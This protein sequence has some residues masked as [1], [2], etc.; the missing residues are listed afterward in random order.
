MPVARHPPYSPG[1]AVFP[2][3]V[4]R[5]SSLPRCTA[6]PSGN[7][8][9]TWNLRH[10]R[11]RYLD[12]V[13]D[14]GTLLPRG[15][16]LLASPPVEPLKRPGHGPM[17]EA[18]AR[19][20]VPSHAIGVVVASQSRMQTLED[21]PPRQMPVLFEPCREPLASGVEL[22]ACGAP[23]DAR[24]T[25]PIWCPAKRESQPGEAPLR[26]WVQTAEP[27][28][29]GCLWCPLAVALRPPVGP[30]SHKPFRVRLPA[31]GPPPVSRLSAPPCFSPTA[32]VHSLSKPSV[33]GRV[34]R[35]IGE[36]GRDRPAL[37]RPSLGMDALAIRV[38]NTCLQPWA[39]QGEQGPIVDAHAPHV[40]EPRRVP[41][42]EGSNNFIPLSTTHWETTWEKVKSQ[43]PVIHSSGVVLRWSRRARAPTVWA[44]FSSPTA[45]PWCCGFPRPPPVWSRHR[46][47]PNR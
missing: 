44:L 8:A 25:V 12:A 10:T 34:Q 33:Q 22:L 36:A 15:A 1:R 23:Q 24:H 40:H 7:H 17:E 5:L 9:P 13:E 38:H 30:H 43:T 28:Q 21:C 45:T 35:D 6:E 46:Q 2:P 42:L 47:S 37:G 31:E 11:T 16:P 41:R 19:A 14:G 18:V 27:A 32:W 29:M 26:A 20:R 3:P 39:K 4:L